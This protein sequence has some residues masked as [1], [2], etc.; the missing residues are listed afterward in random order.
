MT[1]FG[2]AR[3]LLRTS[4]RSAAAAPAQG[5][6]SYAGYSPGIALL[7]SAASAWAY[8]KRKT[9]NK[10]LRTDWNTHC[11]DWEIESVDDAKGD[12]F[13]VAN[14]ALLVDTQAFIVR[15]RIRKPTRGGVEEQFAI[16]VFRGTEFG[17]V[18]LT[19]I[20]TDINTE[21]V[22]Y[23]D[24]I[25]SSVHA[26]FLRS[27]KYVWPEIA[28]YLEGIQKNP[29]KRID[30]LFVTGHSLGGALAVL[31]TCELLDN[32]LSMLHDPIRGDLREKFRG[33]YTFGQPMVGDQAFADHYQK[34]VGAMTFRHVYQYDLVPRF[35]PRTAGNFRHFGREFT[36]TRTSPWR[37]HRLPARQ[38]F[39]ATLAIPI[40]ILAFILRQ[41][42][43]GQ[44]ISLPVSL[45]DHM[46]Q[47]YV[48]CSKL[49]NA[50]T[51]FP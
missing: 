1:P 16:L 46:P 33:C 20:Y 9:L 39:A 18:T 28:T 37:E 4:A 10:V 24:A 48:D 23:P 19:D 7:L 35:P 22:P 36:G 45:A 2:P 8:S 51:T 41:L 30:H 49:R 12:K 26:G 40:G 13:K 15:G 6:A 43:A 27:F 32:G 11:L 42:P 31:A 29:K 47:N 14:G 34:L 44:K 3:V 50:A 25:G 17:G 21:A 5:G 38:V